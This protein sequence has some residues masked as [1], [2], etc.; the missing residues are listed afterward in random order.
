VPRYTLPLIALLTLL[1]VSRPDDG[2]APALAAAPAQAGPAERGTDAVAPDDHVSYERVEVTALVAPSTVAD[3]L[4]RLGAVIEVRSHDRVQA[5]VPRARL[6]EVAAAQS[7]LRVEQASIAIPFQLPTAVGLIGAT[8]WGQAGFTG[9]G[10]RVAV[11]DTGFAGYQTRQGTTLPERLIVRSFR[12]D[13]VIEGGIDHGMRAAEIVHRVA[14][15][16][17]IYLLSFGTVTELSA[18]V[19]FVVEQRLDVVSFSLGFI[20][21]GP[22]DGTGPVDQIVSRGVA[23]GATWTVAAGNWAEQHW[24]GAFTDSDGDSVHEFDSGSSQNGR[25]YEAGDLIIVSL[26]WNDEWGAAC[27]DYDL[28]LFGPSGSLIRASRG[29][30]NC[31]GDPVEGLQ[32]LATESGTYSVRLIRAT[33]DQQRELDLLFIGSPGRGNPLD[34]FV[35]SRSLSEP[36]D[37]PGVVTVGAVS[38]FSPFELSA[39]S[40]RGPTTDGRMKPE[41][42]SPTSVFGTLRGGESFAGT[43]AAA[44]HAAGVAAL[45]I[46]AFPTASATQIRQQLLLRAEVSPDAGSEP[47]PVQLANAGSLAGLGLLLPAGADEAL[48]VGALP[49]AGG[50]ASIVYIG[51]DGYPLRF[52]HLLMGQQVPTTWFRFD[53]GEQKWDVY[54]VGAPGFVNSFVMVRNGDVLFVQLVAPLANALAVGTAIVP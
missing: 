9:Y 42:S 7:I 39:F 41:L 36:A 51:P 15:R 14:P 2:F 45:V 5:L 18:V 3:F 17:E 10:V 27:S 22:G 44:P 40:S 31:A 23:S 53:V 24:S 8:R 20:H 16:A 30:Q 6:S 32:V 37:H 50:I 49:S 48:A 29:I 46:E 21:N 38:L 43:S 13:G 12:A 26:R 28:E 34:A 25:E 52:G 33:D 19:D 4:E 11:I 54:V 35:A 1:L 47:S